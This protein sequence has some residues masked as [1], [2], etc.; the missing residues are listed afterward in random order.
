VEVFNAGQCERSG[1]DVTVI[2]ISF[3]CDDLQANPGPNMVTDRLT[4]PLN[5][6]HLWL[7]L[8]AR[9]LSRY[10]ATAR[11]GGIFGFDSIASLTGTVRPQSRTELDH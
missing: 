8:I 5:L 1:I 4:H 3:R 7:P 9:H 10:N 6:E 2:V 11:G